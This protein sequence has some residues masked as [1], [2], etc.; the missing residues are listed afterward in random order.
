MTNVDYSQVGKMVNLIDSIKS[1]ASVERQKKLAARL[2]QDRKFVTT[3]TQSESWVQWGDM[4]EWLGQPFNVTKIPLNKLEQMRRDPI[5]AFGLLF[6]KVPLVRAHWHIESTDPQ[7][8][9]F[10]DYALRRIYGRFILAWANCFDYGFSPIIKRFEYIQ[11]DWTYID[12]ETNEDKEVW[13]D[14][15][16]KALVWKPF[17]PLNPRYARPKFNSKGEFVGIDFI[18][19][20][21]SFSSF[22]F[23]GGTGRPANVP[24]DW[25]LW[26]TNEK[27]SEFG[28]LF[29][30]PRI[31]Y[32]YRFW[33][34]Y[35]Y[36]FGLSDRAFEKWGDPPVMVFYPT[37][38]VFDIEG[39]PVD[40][41]TE[42][43]NL[44]E[45]LRSGA[46]A[47]IPG[48]TV[49]NAADERATSLR[50][51]AVEQL[52]SEAN[53][54]ALNEA[55][56]Y[57]DIQKLRSIL[58]PEQA[59]VEGGGGTSS[60]NVAKEMGD[61]FFESQ[62]VVMEEID[63]L[64]NRYMIPQ[65]L[66]ANYGS[67]GPSCTK[68]TTG[69]DPKDVETLR[70]I[71][72]GIAN[73][74]GEIAEVDMIAVLKELGIPT[75]THKALER[76]LKEMTEQRDLDFKNRAIEGIIDQSNK[77]QKLSDVNLTDDER[78]GLRKFFNIILGRNVKHDEEEIDNTE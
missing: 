47:A 49:R 41:G 53:F 33:W 66:E 43:L 16:V 70:L 38:D 78:S 34:S 69:F 68:V 54:N 9:A 44:A 60:R 35:W 48:D 61:I 7:R 30:Y 55:F 24:L 22:S 71:I 15:N 46:N 11:P 73:S 77:Q 3:Q 65:L 36:K 74:R 62:A 21:S 39:N 59:L 4:A 45:Q 1:N 20:F 75:L 28:S 32:A 2:A 67:G 40:L 29:G 57:L 6:C 64:I 76:R 19:G 27:D 8:A 37:E 50:R 25:A 51:W 17:T 14:K 56:E 5:L 12:P 13:P 52:K 10:I 58:I 72:G 42:A 18:P 26:A 31:G 23:G 63:D